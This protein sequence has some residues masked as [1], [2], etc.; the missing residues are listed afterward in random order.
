VYAPVERR[1]GPGN[2][3]SASLDASGFSRFDTCPTPGITTRQSSETAPAIT[4]GWRR[5]HRQGERSNRRILGRCGGVVLP[6]CRYH[7]RPLPPGGQLR[8]L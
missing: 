5:I 8:N 4:W 6:A 2:G 7:E 3:T 1:S